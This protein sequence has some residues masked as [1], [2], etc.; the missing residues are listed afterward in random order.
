MDVGNHEIRKFELLY[1]WLFLFWKKMYIY[2]DTDEMVKLNQYLV[3]VP[4]C[5]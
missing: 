4:T 3:V 1:L 5:F 2:I